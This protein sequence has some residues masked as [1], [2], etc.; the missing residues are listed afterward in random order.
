MK[1]KY[2][3]TLSLIVAL[4][5][6]FC[7]KDSTGPEENGSDGSSELSLY[8]H[9]TAGVVPNFVQVMFQVLDA[10]VIGK[11]DLEP[12]DFNVR[13]DETPINSFMVRGSTD[14][15][16]RLKTFLVI[17]N[18]PSADLEAIKNAAAQ[19]INGMLPNQSIAILALGDVDP[20]Y[21]DFSDNQV[22]LTVALL[23]LESGGTYR[24][25]YGSVYDAF[26][27]YEGIYTSTLVDQY[28]MVLVAAGEDIR[29][30]ETIDDAV[31]ARGNSAIWTIGAGPGTNSVELEQLG[32][33]NYIQVNTSS[34]LDNAIA[35]VQEQL[36][37]YSDG[38]YFIQYASD[39]RGSEIHAVDVSLVDNTNTDADA[40]FTGT[41]SS[42]D[43]YSLESGLYVNLSDWFPTG[44]DTVWI[45]TNRN[46]QLDVITSDPA[47]L[48]DYLWQS[49]NP[50]TV[51]IE[52]DPANSAVA[53][54]SGLGSD[55]DEA[56]VTI[57]DVANGLQKS[58]KVMVVD[59]MAGYILREVWEDMEG[60]LMGDLTD[61]PDYPDNPTFWE[62]ISSFEC[63]TD[64]G[65]NFGVRVRGYVVPPTSG[66]YTFWIASDDYSQLWLSTDENPDNLIRI[67]SVVGWTNSREWDKYA[68]QQSDPVSLV[69][70]E[71]YYIEAL[72]KEGTGGDNLSVAWQGPGIDQAVI[73]GAY[74]G[75]VI[76][77]R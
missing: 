30:A 75:P 74:L 15:D 10:N 76:M 36:V 26:T 60:Y 45:M 77:Y 23:N 51:G 17:D 5:L 72:F 48:P 40:S 64:A 71:L 34:E 9:S 19:I 70:G 11:S 7:G 29:A 12:D 63:P 4:G 50:S 33:V 13:E 24:N 68:D 73:D 46:V 66:E 56:T 2:L 21:Y 8:L 47:A 37:A 31:A 38:F 32:N 43:L 41:Y 18:T 54:I 52:M 61:H 53:T 27:R 59:Y 28:T 55:G 20:F 1:V 67:A 25:I 39:K 14:L 65:D 22:S 62:Y 16:Y 3:F 42:A 49:S 69:A 35:D 58:V 44:L 57:Q 6:V